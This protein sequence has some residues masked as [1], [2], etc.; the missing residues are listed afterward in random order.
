MTDA[1]P[2]QSGSGYHPGATL[3][4]RL[5]RQ[6]RSGR[7]VTGPQP[8]VPELDTADRLPRR[9]T[10]ETAAVWW[11]GVHGG[12]GESTLAALAAGTKAAGHAWP[13]PADPAAAA[14]RVVL[15]ARTNYTGLIGAQRAAIDWASDSLG[16][17]VTLEGLV[18][19]ADMPGR[20]PKPLRDLE[21]VVAG[22]APRSWSLPWID[23]WRYGPAAPGTPL[24]RPFHDLLAELSLTP[25][26]TSAHNRKDS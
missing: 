18:L 25:T 23:A 11:L 19:I 20:R 3:P 6:T 24:P 10:T 13:L 12:A 17:G 7:S 2:Q 4:S 22:G 8:G 5:S 26:S 21:Q 16:S 14:H 9:Q 1:N 15:V